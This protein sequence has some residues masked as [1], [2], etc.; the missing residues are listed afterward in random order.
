MVYIRKCP[1]CNKD[2]E[3]PE[4][5]LF[6]RA[7]K[8]SRCCKKCIPIKSKKSRIVIILERNCPKCNKLLKYNSYHSWWSSKK[9][10]LVCRSCS[11]LGK[12]MPKG[13]SEKISRIVSGKGNPM[14]GKHHTQE[15]KDFISKLNKGNKGNKAG[16]GYKFSDDSKQKMREA[17][18]RRIKKYGIHS[19]NFNPKACKIIDEY[20]KNNG[21]KFQHALNGG[22]LSVIGYLVDGYDKEKNVVFEYDE[23]HHFDSSGKLKSKD[24]NRMNE[25]KNQLKCKFFRYNEL[26]G[27]IEEY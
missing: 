14:Y 17:V 13:F 20:G 23:R 5:Y 27:K 10:N 24:F 19:R 7:E 4:K 11:K 25:I 22:E 9:R 12:I 16:L 1:I 8:E 6:N 18:I 3:Y 2:I 15:M 26:T 21:Y